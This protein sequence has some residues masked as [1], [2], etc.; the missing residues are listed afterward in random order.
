[1]LGAFKILTITH[2]RNQLN[3]L[4]QFAFQA[5]DEEVLKEEL[6]VVK[7][8]YQLG[9]LM[10]LSTC[11]RIMYFFFTPTPLDHDFA[12]SFIQS[13]NP[14]ISTEVLDDIND[15]IDIYSG[16]DALMHLF[17]VAASIDS[18]V[19]GEREILR[20]LREAYARSQS[21]GF[22]G[23]NIRLAIKTTVESAKAVYSQTRIGEK[24]VS[25]VSLS[26]Q[27]LLAAPVSRNARIL[28]IGAGQTNTLVA[29][30][31]VKHQYTNVKVFN[32]SLNKAQQIAAMLKGEA[33][34]LAALE[35]WKEGFDCIIIC[36]GSTKA[37]IDKKLYTQ[38]LGGETD[39]KVLIDLAIPNNISTEVVEQFPVH[40]IEI[41]D[42]RSLA[43]ENL[44][45]REQE[46]AKAKELLDDQMADFYT[47]YKQRQIERAMRKVPTEIKAVKAH[48]MNQVFRKELESLDKE[49]RELLERM[50]TYMEKQCISIPMKAAKEVVS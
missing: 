42:L 30:F 46:V 40:Y 16:S 4:G 1:M 20:Q 17:E 39:K 3:Q 22:T 21:W 47:L 24:P 43:R 33:Y 11:N 50:M 37:L 7:G 28:L 26:I 18:L 49:S 32:R 2:R 44:S 19:V 27:K 25:I 23:D 31:L 34:D 6:T 14:L 48:A 36:T 38:L 45:F 41:D 15:Y 9:E 29:K 35:S 8:Q 13:V 10:Y 5:N 12:S